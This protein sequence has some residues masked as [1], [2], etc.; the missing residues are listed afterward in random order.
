MMT[1]EIL[2]SSL[3]T[4]ISVEQI[5]FVRVC[6]HCDME[7]LTIDPDQIYPSPS[8]RVR[9]FQIRRILSESRLNAPVKSLH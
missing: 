1:I 4:R 6:P 8:H 7:F 5:Q 2:S 9:A 3:R